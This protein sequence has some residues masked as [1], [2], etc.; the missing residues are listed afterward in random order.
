MQRLENLKTRHTKRSHEHWAICKCLLAREIRDTI[1]L[2]VGLEQANKI[3]QKEFNNAKK[4][5]GQ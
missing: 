2:D 4:A 3:I 1:L 5:S